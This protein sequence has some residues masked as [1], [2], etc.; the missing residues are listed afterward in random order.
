V[1]FIKRIPT[2]IP[3]LDEVIEGGFPS[4]SVLLLLGE[5]G[6]GKTTLAMQSLFYGAKNGET[7]IYM[8]GVAEPVFMIKKFMSNFS[9]YEG[10]FIENSKIQ[11]WDL[12]SSIQTMGTKKALDAITDIVRETNASRVIIDP[13]PLAQLFSSMSDYRKYLYD[14]LTALRNLQVFTIIIGE[15]SDETEND[16]ESYMVDAVILLYLRPLD[17]PLVYKNLLRIRK[18]RG[19][20]HVRDMLSVDITKDGMR[21]YRMA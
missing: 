4:P 12:G 5:P 11:F 8:T 14:F 1:I 19:T 17:N 6:T 9:F 7:V 18:M 10:S 20:N 15:K 13:L 3:G 2:G 16:L 21:I